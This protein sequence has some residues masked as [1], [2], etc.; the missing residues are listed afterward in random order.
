M[1]SIDRY[2]QGPTVHKQTSFVI[3]AC[4]CNA[5]QQYQIQLSSIRGGLS[6]TA[7]K[8]NDDGEFR[9][10]SPSLCEDTD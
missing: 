2:I 9:H 4:Y 3:D 10:L 5:F 7:M 6:V 1:I 8:T